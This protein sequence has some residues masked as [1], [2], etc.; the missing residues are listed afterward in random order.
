MTLRNFEI[1]AA[2]CK[3]MNMS[4][5]AK[6]LYITTPAV[7]QA[8]SE[9]ERYYGVELF[10]RQGRR[11]YLTHG[12]KT[13]LCGVA[14]LLNEAAAVEQRMFHEAENPVI[15]LGCTMSVSAT[16]LPYMV[17][18]YMRQNPQVQVQL[19]AYIASTL[20]AMLLDGSL[21]FAIIAGEIDPA[22]FQASPFLDDEQVFI[23]HKAHPILAGCPSE[24]PE[25][26]LD[27][28]MKLQLIVRDKASSTYSQICASLQSI[29]A[30]YEVNGIISNIDGIILAVSCGL[31]ISSVSKFAK[32]RE[33]DVRRFR[34]RGIRVARKFNLVQLRDRELQPAYK[35]LKEFIL[36]YSC[37]SS[38]NRLL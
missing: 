33:P 5:A 1:F 34:I 29:G 37:D 31:G 21:D 26:T 32:I 13:L 2:V 22:Q 3:Y 16:F 11:L 17:S 27:P 4:E 14:P 18:D 10:L 38:L 35:K 36:A 20:K 24:F 15:R 28:S 23:A 12:G 8:I 7:S 19:Y 25:I 9:M 30:N 6:S